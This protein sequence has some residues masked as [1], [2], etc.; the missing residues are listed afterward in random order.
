[1]SVKHLWRKRPVLSDQKHTHKISAKYNKEYFD[2]YM[3]YN[4]I[5][6]IKWINK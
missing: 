3:I 5:M 1:M 2:V 4:D 6:R